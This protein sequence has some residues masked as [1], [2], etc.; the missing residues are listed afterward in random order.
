V[1]NFGAKPK[2][3]IADMRKEHLMRRIV[4]FPI[5]FL[6]VLAL[7][8]GLCLKAAEAKSDPVELKFWSAWPEAVLSEADQ[9]MIVAMIKT[10]GKA[11]NLDVR[12]VGGP[13]VFAT[14]EA[15]DILQRGGFDLAFT[16]APHNMGVVPEEDVL[17]LIQTLPWEDR[18][19][20]AFDL[21]NK[22][23]REKGLEYLARPTH[24]VKFQ[25]YLNV[26]QKKPD[27]RG[28]S[29]RLAP[30]YTGIIK[31]L[32]GT[33]TSMAGGEIYT[34]LQRGTIDGIW[35]GGGYAIT[36]WGWQE[37]LK[38]I[39]GPSFWSGDV[40]VLMNRKKYDSLSAEQKAT[41]TGI[42][43][44][45]ERK[46]YELQLKEQ[47]K[48]KEDLL[49]AGLKEIKFS[50]EDEAKYLDIVYSEGW[51]GAVERSARVNELKPL[52]SKN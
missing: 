17:K 7:S 26:D 2:G 4:V 15:C 31:A 25:A 40:V 16:A 41:L 12:Y 30:I 13:E 46:S 34:A 39:W 33:G 51:R 42:M 52:I 5:A 14:Y 1:K 38:Y 10:R 44:D 22:W 18:E 27:L 8:A 47:I 11:V 19:S 37:I 48:C 45:F 9:R 50:K 28:I 23:H 43:A 24:A 29:M 35:W 6:V 36:S 3:L 21:L 32:G 20:G 49:A